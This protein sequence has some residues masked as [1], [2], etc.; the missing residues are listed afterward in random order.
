MWT[1]LQ[2]MLLSG[3]KS[4]M[5]N[6]VSSVPTFMWKKEGKEYNYTC[7]RSYL[8][9]APIHW[10]NWLS[11]GEAGRPSGKKHF[12]CIPFGSFWVWS[13]VNS[14]RIQITTFGFSK[15]C[16]E[17]STQASCLIHKLCTHSPPCTFLISTVA[18]RSSCS[19]IDS[20][21]ILS[22]GHPPPFQSHPFQNEIGSVSSDLLSVQ[23]Q[24]YLLALFCSLQD[25]SGPILVSR[26]L[27]F[28]FVCLRR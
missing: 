7:V 22:S 28:L 4:K 20:G 12:H 17:A 10:W 18:L 23:A 14:L 3:G 5:W 19:D 11:L 16:G 24:L 6:S 13:L 26:D 2:Y 21:T 27:N 1:V 9:R 25:P 8:W 15:K